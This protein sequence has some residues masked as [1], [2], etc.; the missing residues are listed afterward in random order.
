M[1]V[2]LDTLPLTGEGSRPHRGLRTQPG[3]SRVLITWRRRSCL[4]GFCAATSCWVITPGLEEW[5]AAISRGL[6]AC[7]L[8][9]SLGVGGAQ[10][11]VVWL[12]QIR[13]LPRRVGFVVS[14][15]QTSE[16]SAFPTLCRARIDC[17][18]HIIKQPVLSLSSNWKT[19]SLNREK[20]G[21]Y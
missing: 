4:T 14:A 5:L 16:K 3:P 7:S 21:V 18:L 19:E 17:C 13:C 12:R 8:L 10:S 15:T 20:E 1:C 11:W 6:R 9:L 2:R